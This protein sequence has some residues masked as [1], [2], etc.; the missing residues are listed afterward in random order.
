ML[1]DIGAEVVISVE[2]LDQ[3]ELGGGG[4]GVMQ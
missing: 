1:L 2:A 3:E 4:G